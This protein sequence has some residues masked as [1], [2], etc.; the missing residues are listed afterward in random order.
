MVLLWSSLLL[1]GPT[2]I[3]QHSFFVFLVYLF[4]I[5]YL[6]PHNVSPIHWSIYMVDP[7]CLVVF[8]ILHLGR[9]FY[10]YSFEPFAFISL[11]NSQTAQADLH[12]ILQYSFA[13]TAIYGT[14]NMHRYLMLH[15]QSCR[16]FPRAVYVSVFLLFAC[17]YC[18]SRLFSFLTMLESGT[19]VMCVLFIFASILFLRLWLGN[20]SK[21]DP[22]IKS[23]PEIGQI[24]KVCFNTAYWTA[25]FR[26]ELLQYS[27]VIFSS[28]ANMTWLWLWLCI[29]ISVSL[30]RA[31]ESLFPFDYSLI[32]PSV[33][34]RSTCDNCSS[35]CPPLV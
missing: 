27:S 3:L 9:H 28:S 32:F 26:V 34:S 29:F 5:A 30:R 24:E 2:G 15:Y 33:W 14:I 10:F 12:S 20:A 6:F 11:E 4:F 19:A 23:K 18:A 22:A 7:V 31:V 17:P 35:F 13:S 16:F 25:W 21:T 8:C 1:L